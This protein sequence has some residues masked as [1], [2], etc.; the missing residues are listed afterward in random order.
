MRKKHE[1]ELR[2]EERERLLAMVKKGE[3]KAYRVLRANI[4]LLADEGRTDQAIAEAL[5]VGHATVE[6]IRERFSKEGLEPAL[7][8]RERVTP[9]TLYKLDG[10]AEAH[11]IALVCGP[12]PE[13]HARWSLRLLA[14]RF[15][16]LGHVESISHETVRQVL[17]KKRP[18]AMAQG[19]VGY[20]A[21]GK[22]R[23]RL[24]H[25]RRAGGLSASSRSQ[26]AADLSG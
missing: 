14:E 19:T 15:V 13:G 7:S 2:E 11:L 23:V 1:V 22:R 17:K 4:L 20:R 25:G 18:Q 5:H 26:P 3:E 10:S 8:R 9:P 6:R 21:K 24:A 12:P 16:V